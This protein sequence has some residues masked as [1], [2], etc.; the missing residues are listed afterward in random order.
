MRIENM[1]AVVYAQKKVLK[2]DNIDSCMLTGIERLLTPS[3]I[4][5]TKACRVQC[6]NAVLEEESNQVR[7]GV[8]D[9][10][11]IAMASQYHSRS[12]ARRA[13]AIGMLNAR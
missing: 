4:K 11:R 1:K 8:Y 6:V 10:E 12:A 2:D 9:P 7:A 13:R 5:K 3:A